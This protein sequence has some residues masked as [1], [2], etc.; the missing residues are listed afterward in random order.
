[1]ANCSARRQRVGVFQIGGVEALG[2]PVVDLGE[3]RPRFIA[4]IGIS[5]QSRQANRRAELQRLCFS[6][7]CKV[8]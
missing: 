4:A 3:H 2:E 8:V 1:M 7:A 6:T 5:Q